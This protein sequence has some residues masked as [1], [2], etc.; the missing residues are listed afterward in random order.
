MVEGYFDSESVNASRSLRV[1]AAS[2]A[3]QTDARPP[4]PPPTPVGLNPPARQCP[5]EQAHT[6]PWF[7]TNH[8]S[9]NGFCALVLYLP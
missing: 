5:R 9:D 3:P 1:P 4:A 6:E 2:S 7:A 8:S